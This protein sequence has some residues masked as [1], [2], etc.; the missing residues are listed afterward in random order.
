[1]AQL[2]LEKLDLNE[3]KA[4]QKD[5]AAAIDNFESRRRTEALKALEATAREHGYN[6]DQLVGGSQAAKKVVVP[7][8]ANPD[9]PGQSWSGRGRKPQWVV[10]ALA[11]GKTLED[12]A[13]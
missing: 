11:T 13:I 3:L 2:D 6:I 10:D 7:K 1:M 9:N 4:L 8:Y 12:L 5:I